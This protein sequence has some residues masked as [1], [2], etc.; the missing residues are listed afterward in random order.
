M[1][2]TF[3]LA[4]ESVL[5]DVYGL[6]DR[7]IQWMDDN[8]IQQWNVTGYWE[9][10]PRSYYVRMVRKRCLYVLKREADQ[11]TVSAAV[12]FD[13]DKRWHDDPMFPAYYVHNFVTAPEEKGVGKILLSYIE[14][15]ARKKGK[16]CIR[17][18]C[19]RSNQKLN[20]YYEQQG[21]ILRG[22][23]ADGNYLGN[24][25]E[26]VFGEIQNGRIQNEH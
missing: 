6:I 4:D 7:R 3:I 23:C 17:L 18:D 8:D 9:A 26:K 24:K 12:L 21:Y 22:Q 11:K 2:Y 5:E 14:D 25:R 19:S 16:V 20:R 10:Y 13:E 1:N 15:L